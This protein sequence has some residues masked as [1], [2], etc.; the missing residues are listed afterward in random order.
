MPILNVFGSSVLKRELNSFSL[1]EPR[2]NS[3]WFGEFFVVELALNGKNT[4]M[5]RKN[6][7]LLADYGRTEIPIVHRT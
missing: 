2:I 6:V 1:V 4:L 5:G 7:F 3:I